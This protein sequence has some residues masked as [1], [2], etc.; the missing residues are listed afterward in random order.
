MSTSSSSETTPAAGPDAP[1][2]SAP[3]SV[4]ASEDSQK[5]F[6]THARF[7]AQEATLASFRFSPRPY[8]AREVLLTAVVLY[9]TFVGLPVLAGL[10]AA[11][12]I[13]RQVH[14]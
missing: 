9:G 8:R 2:G 10:W 12:R 3:G 6:A 13:W 5:F 4:P 11:W 1:N 14:G 7:A